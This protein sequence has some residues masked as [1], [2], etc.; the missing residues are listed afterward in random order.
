MMVEH[1]REELMLQRQ[2]TADKEKFEKLVK[3]Q[4]ANK[5][6]VNLKLKQLKR[7]KKW[8]ET[9]EQN[10]RLLEK[11]NMTVEHLREELM[12]QRQI[13]A[14]KEENNSNVKEEMISD[15]DYIQEAFEKQN[16]RQD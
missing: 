10:V 9:E 15:K 4:E 8:Q 11:R 12:L 1:L 16:M 2:I 6:L 7:E 3:M 13:T 14:G 5:Q